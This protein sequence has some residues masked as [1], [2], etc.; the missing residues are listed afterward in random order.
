MPAGRIRTGHAALHGD[1]TRHQAGRA[2]G[3]RAPHGHRCQND[4]VYR[5]VRRQVALRREF[6]SPWYAL[7]RP[8]ESG[9]AWRRWTVTRRGSRV[10]EMREFERRPYATILNSASGQLV[11]RRG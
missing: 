1:P 3:V 5:V 11:R 8:D 7:G 9:P 10:V 4:M 2:A 6:G